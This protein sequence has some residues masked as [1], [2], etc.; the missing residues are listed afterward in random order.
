MVTGTCSH[1]SDHGG[2][3]QSNR[4]KSQLSSLHACHPGRMGL[5]FLIHE[6]TKG[7]QS[8]LEGVQKSSSSS[9][10]HASQIKWRPEECW[11]ISVLEKEAAAPLPA[12]GRPPWPEGE[13]V[14]SIWASHRCISM[15]TFS[16][17]LET[18]ARLTETSSRRHL[19]FSTWSHHSLDREYPGREERGTGLVKEAT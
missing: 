9:K 12:D 3:G 16:I 6:T 8:E 14:F 4:G 17:S 7:K 11:Q 19:G 15:A 10:R 2:K 13:G 5:S 1:T 18:R